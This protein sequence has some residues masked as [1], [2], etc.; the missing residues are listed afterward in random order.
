M[1]DIRCIANNSPV[2]S[3]HSTLFK[4]ASSNVQSIG[5]QANNK[6]GVNAANI[7]IVKKINGIEEK[8][9]NTRANAADSAAGKKNVSRHHSRTNSRTVPREV[10][11]S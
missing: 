10:L 9:T 8:A 5:V 4:P 1:V 6:I 2:F 3:F 7:N 11:K